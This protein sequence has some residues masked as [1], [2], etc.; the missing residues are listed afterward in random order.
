M[1]HNE[2]LFRFHV[3]YTHLFMFPPT[4]RWAWKSSIKAEAMIKSKRN[5]M[6]GIL[7]VEA[8]DRR[9]TISIYLSIS[10]VQSPF[11][12]IF[13]LV[14]SFSAARVDKKKNMKHSQHEKRRAHTW[15]LNICAGGN[16]S[17]NLWPHR[18]FGDW[19]WMSFMISS[20]A[21]E[22]FHINQKILLIFNGVSSS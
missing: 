3:C 20:S 7:A 6:C 11:L 15:E 19:C 4:R 21:H 1:I 8:A 14:H 18:V 22:Y 9:E 2:Y 13:L 12:F 10:F 17:D 16:K 5:D